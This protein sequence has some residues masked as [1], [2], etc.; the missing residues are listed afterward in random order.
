MTKVY[1]ND[2]KKHLKFQVFYP[3]AKYFLYIEENTRV[4]C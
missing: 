1:K 3:L 2:R 4:Q